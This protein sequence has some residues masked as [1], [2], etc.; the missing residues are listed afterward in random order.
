M[1]LLCSDGFVGVDTC[2][3]DGI[4]VLPLLLVSSSGVGW[5]GVSGSVE[6][7][8]S[9][10]GFVGFVRCLG[11][12]FLCCPLPSSDA[13]SFCGLDPPSVGPGF[14]NVPKG[15]RGDIF[16]RWFAV[17]WH[18]FAVVELGCRFV[19]VLQV[20]FLVVCLQSGVLLAN[21]ASVLFSVWLTWT[22][23]DTS[24][25]FGSFQGSRSGVLVPREC[26]RSF[27]VSVLGACGCF[28]R[29]RAAVV[30]MSVPSTLDGA[31]L[32][33]TVTRFV[34]SSRFLHA[35]D[36]IWLLSTK[37]STM[38]VVVMAILAFRPLIDKACWCW[39]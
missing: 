10:S 28:L 37:L 11:F 14:R 5:M 8:L 23:S 4:V 3:V 32:A 31:V 20:C 9:G 35:V 18:W 6:V 33:S 24:L 27:P 19:S 29:V 39:S 34:I 25:M 38:G 16:C 1:G 30:L 26:S 21:L 12:G 36:G 22:F 13:C 15:F 2:G 17:S 7:W